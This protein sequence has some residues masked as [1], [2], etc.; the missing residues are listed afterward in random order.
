MQAYAGAATNHLITN[1]LNYW[2]AVPH[3]NYA[4][5]ETGCRTPVVSTCSYSFQYIIACCE[6][7]NIVIVAYIFLQYIT[8]YND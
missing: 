7:K 2:D 3:L 8:Q 1:H 5:H 4:A 6:Y